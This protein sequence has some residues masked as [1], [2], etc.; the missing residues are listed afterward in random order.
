MRTYVKTANSEALETTL[1][2]AMVNASPQAVTAMRKKIAGA[3]EERKELKLKQKPALGDAFQCLLD[4]NETDAV[5]RLFI[6]LKINPRAFI[7]MKWL[8]DA[9][10]NKHGFQKLAVTESLYGYKKIKEIAQYILS[11]NSKLESIV[12]TWTACAIIASR[13]GEPIPREVCKTFLSSIDLEQVS[14]ALASAVRD[15]QAVRALQAVH[16][17]GGK[18]TQTSQMTLVLASLGSGTLVKRETKD[19]IINRQGMV[20]Q[21]LAERFGMLERLQD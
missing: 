17:S 21:A 13:T 5:A 3:I 9:E 10:L 4:W 15:Y 6:G 12:M 18:D 16:M 20:I 14:P 19:I 1:Y 8:D 7:L 2:G 11:G